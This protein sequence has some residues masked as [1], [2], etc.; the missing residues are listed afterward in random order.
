MPFTQTGQFLKID[1]SLGKDVLLLRGFI[2]QEGISQIA[3]FEL[4]LFTEGPPIDFNAVVGQNVTIRVG[5]NDDKERVFNGFISR[6]AQ[7]DRKTGIIHYRAEMVSW[8]WFLTRTSD[9]RIFQEKTIP[10]IIE[11][12]FTELGFFDF[13]FSLQ[14]TYP[15]REFCVQYRETDYDF[16]ARLMEQYGIF[17]FFEHT[18]NKHTLVLAD[19][20]SA[21]QP[22][23]IH[24]E[25]EWKPEESK[26]QEQHVIT[27][28]EFEKELRSG[29]FSHT[30]YNFKTP[31]TNLIVEES[32]VV[33]IG[34]NQQYEIYDYPGEYRAKADGATLAKIRMQEEEALH[35]VISGSSTCQEFTSGYTFDLTNYQP[36]DL[37]QSYVLTE[38]H[39]VGSV[40]E[41]YHSGSTAG[42]KGE[43]SNTFTCIPHPVPFRPPQVTPK[44][45][46]QG[47][48]TAIVAGPQG[49]EIWCDE[50]G[51]INVHFHWDREGNKDET[52][53]VWMRVSQVHAGKGFGGLDT[54]RIGEEVI[55]SFL[56]GDPDRPIITGRVYNAE[57]SIPYQLPA[58]KTKSTIKSSSSKGGGNSNELRFEDKTGSEEV[59]L[60]GAKDWTIAIDHDKNQTVRHNET[61]TVRNDR[62]R[63]VGNNESIR[64]TKNRVT[65]VGGHQSESVR[66]NHNIQVGGNHSE[67][68]KG[69]ETVKIG[70][71]STHAIASSKALSIG[72]G[73]QV[74]VGA[75]MQETIGANRAEEIARTKSVAVGSSS[76]ETVGANKSINVGG[77]ISENAG[78]N[79]SIHADSNLSETAG[80]DVRIEAGKDMTLIAQGNLTIK[81]GNASITLRKNGDILINGQKVQVVAKKDISMKAEGNIVKKAKKI[82]ESQERKRTPRTTSRKG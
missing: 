15:Q 9:C 74:N 65:S 5:L 25:V 80:K 67:S 3:R 13:K 61:H 53:S 20:P 55:V 73:F 45:I 2:G 47:P 56:E 50:F 19:A 22:I 1:T 77:N 41:T 39:H 70:R 78:K 11:Q 59:Y 34:N 72:A 51:R 43:Y 24:P 76:S 52:S 64:I 33:N 75:T 12:I 69:S 28:L 26:L 44:P 71:S 79:I 57:Q 21:H 49:E 6:F 23:S 14:G 18:E 8:L 32:S 63:S 7:T 58:E 29:K 30:D 4:D 17:Y 36:N 68:I 46:V 66:A 38:V 40:G 81:N 10:D 62:T 48:Q 37:N 31:S 16:V 35:Y 42:S 27:S 54:P 82:L 60:H